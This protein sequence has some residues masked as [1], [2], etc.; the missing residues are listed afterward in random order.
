[1]YI[2]H[3]FV[4]SPD[5][6]GAV[7]NTRRLARLTEAERCSKR[8]YFLNFAIKFNADRVGVVLLCSKTA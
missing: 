1:M 3:T 4:I 8:F 7:N 2:I 6:V 5:S